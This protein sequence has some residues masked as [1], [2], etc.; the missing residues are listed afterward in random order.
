MEIT[1]SGQAVIAGAKGDVIPVRNMASK[2]IVRGVV[3]NSNTV[4]IMSIGEEHA[5]NE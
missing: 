3:E 4:T 5:E 1:T 2:K